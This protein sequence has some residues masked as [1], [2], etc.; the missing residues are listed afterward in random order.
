MVTYEVPNMG[1]DTTQNRQSVFV[2]G[3]SIGFD[4]NR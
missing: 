2:N 4:I 3:V 1:I